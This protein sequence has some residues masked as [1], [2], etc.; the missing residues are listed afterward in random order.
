MLSFSTIA[1]SSTIQVD[2]TVP[3]DVYDDY[4]KVIE[5]QN[6]I[7]MSNFEHTNNRRDVVELILLQQALDKGKLENY[8]VNFIVVD[9]Y[10]RAL[11]LLKSG[12][13]LMTGTSLWSQD[14]VD[15]HS[16][17][18]SVAIIKKNQ[19]EAG[20]YTSEK[21]Y[22]ELVSKQFNIE[23]LIVVSSKQWSVDWQTLNKLPFKQVLEVN[24]WNSMLKMVQANRA[25]IL[26]APFQATADMSLV[27]D[28]NVYKPLP[29]IK[30]GLLDSRH[31]AISKNNKNHQIVY[32]AL[33]K[34]LKQ[35][36]QERVIIKAYTQSGFM[37][38]KVRNWSFI[39]AN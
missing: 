14:I 31:Y 18:M 30:I 15:D 6:P 32:L 19:F 26:L 11:R 8:K 29:N 1:Q 35:L 22:A 9:P 17:I 33:K 2:I 12:K 13:A 25:D 34:G 21:K 37:N 3:S 23:E 36:E 5:H 7:T 16:L 27:I 10:F 24:S 20:L 38:V 4:L 39:N 28:S